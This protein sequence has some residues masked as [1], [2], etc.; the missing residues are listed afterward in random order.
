MRWRRPGGADQARVLAV[1]DDWWGA[2]GGEAGSRQRALLLPRLFFQHF[3]DTS[4]LGEATD[5]RLT[6][7]LI[8]FRSAAQP[9]AAYIHFVGV[10]PALRRRGVAAGLYRWFFAQAAAGGARRV[11]AI[12]SPGNAT[13]V[14]FHTAIG[15]R[16]IPGRRTVD[17]VDV[18]V[19]YD[20]PGLHRIAFTRPLTPADTARASES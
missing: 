12:T 20:G 6:A 11:D 9:D 7:F 10:D 17:G 19:D 4:L 15:F 13:S 8:G 2:L 18:Q 5:G 3:A 1:L 16:I 14:A